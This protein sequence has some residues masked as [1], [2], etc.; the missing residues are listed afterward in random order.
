MRGLLYLSGNPIMEKNT[1]QS[2]ALDNFKEDTIAAVSTA[3]GE[4]GIGIVRVSGPD[5]LLVAAKIFGEGRGKPARDLVLEDRRLTYGKVYDPASME[6]VDEVLAVYMKAPHTY[7]CE[8]VVEIHC[9]GSV[10]SLRKILS[11]CLTN[12]A[13]AAEKGE[14]TKRAFLNGRLDLS[15]AE[16]V[17]DLISARTDDSLKTAVDQLDGHL[18]RAVTDLRTKLMDELVAIG[19]NMDYP[20]E[21]IEEVLYQDLAEHLREIL[22]GIRAL[23]DTAGTGRLLREG[24]AVAIAGRPNVGKSSLLNGLLGAERAI[25]TDIPGTTRDVITEYVDMGGIPVQLVDTAGIRE[26]D[27]LIEK[28]GI[29][30]SYESVKQADLVLFVV[31]GSEPLTGEDRRIAEGLAGEKTILLLNKKDLKEAVTEQDAK[32]LLP[33]AVIVKTSFAEGREADT[34]PVTEAIREKVLSGDVRQENSVVV[35]NARHEAALAKAAKSLEDAIRMTEAG[36]ALDI[37]EIDVRDCYESLGEI[38]GE[39]LKDD[40]IEEIFARFCLGK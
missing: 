16:A 26:A 24:L 4:G 27:D 11:L 35:T 23:L 36:E 33:G 28:I 1:A 34:K 14:F 19:V 8:D 32:A 31:D 38:L 12:G 2:A 29:E 39:T 18:S 21:D 13:R 5:A 9:H 15:Q 20:D 25:V 40:I 6:E 30:K 10:V 3:F 37:L 22:S 7:T 17:M